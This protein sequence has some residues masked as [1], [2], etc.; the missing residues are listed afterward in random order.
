MSWDGDCVRGNRVRLNEWWD[1]IRVGSAHRDQKITK[2][3]GHTSTNKN[4]YNQ[5]QHKICIGRYI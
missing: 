1:L 5:L 4:K 3:R 2:K